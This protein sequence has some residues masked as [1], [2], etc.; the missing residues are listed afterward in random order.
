MYAP[1]NRTLLPASVGCYA[2][3]DD[4]DSGSP[5]PGYCQAGFFD[6]GGL[7]V[8]AA[9]PLT[10][11]SYAALAGSW[12][13]SGRPEPEL[14]CMSTP[15]SITQANGCITDVSPISFAS[16]TD[17][18]STTAMVAEK[19]VSTL[20]PFQ[21]LNI[22]S[23]NFY[24]QNGWWFSGN[25]GRT[26]VTSYYPPNAY[27]TLPIWPN[28]TWLA[29]A[30]SLHPGGLNVLMADGSTRFVKETIN[31]QQFDPITLIPSSSG[32]WQALAT[33]NGGELLGTDSY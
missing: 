23:P 3:P 20:R 30:S 15:E 24:Q 18:L 25:W 33:R 8:G 7:S 12:L 17:G 13:M 26:L 5:R 1:A 27:K 11:T 14:N 22:G 6:T 21:T 32:I 29:S 10:A 28:G 16:I 19:C 31:S 4:V 2:C 9:M